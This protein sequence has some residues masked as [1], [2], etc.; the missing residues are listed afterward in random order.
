MIV[1]LSSFSLAFVGPGPSLYRNK[2][3]YI[4]TKNTLSEE[5]TWNLRL[6]LKGVATEKG[7]KVDEIIS[8]KIQFV[9]DVGYEPPQGTIRQLDGSE[10]KAQIKRSRWILSEDPKDRKWGLWIWGLFEEPLYPFLLLT[11]QV[12]GTPQDD[13]DSLKP[14]ALYAQINHR[15]EADVGVVLEGSDL[16]VRRQETVNAD[17]FG[18]AKADIV[19]DVKTGTILIQPTTLAVAR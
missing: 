14:L 15:R 5:S 17:I 4:A 9:E 16:F 11:L 2:C 18:A 7:K 8:S 3:L 19:D 6:V 12:E 13:G 10:S 1:T